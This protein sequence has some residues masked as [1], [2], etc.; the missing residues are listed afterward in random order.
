ML[1][2]KVQIFCCR[3]SNKFPHVNSAL[4][5]CGY[6]KKLI[7]LKWSLYHCVMHK[8]QFSSLCTLDGVFAARF[9]V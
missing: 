7:L 8:A 1:G 2:I 5:G 4:V 9:K 3:F 6:C